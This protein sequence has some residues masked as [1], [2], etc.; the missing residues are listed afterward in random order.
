[1]ICTDCTVEAVGISAIEDTT[2]VG[3]NDAAVEVGCAL[4]TVVEEAMFVDTATS[5]VR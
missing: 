3:C 2:D 1:M 5:V 4:T